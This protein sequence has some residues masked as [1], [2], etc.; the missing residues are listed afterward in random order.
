[1]KY[2]L[3]V[4]QQQRRPQCHILRAFAGCDQ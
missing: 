4:L 1:M 3:V 2:N